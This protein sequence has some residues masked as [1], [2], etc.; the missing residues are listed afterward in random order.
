MAQRSVRPCAAPHLGSHRPR[1]H[2]SPRAVAQWVILHWMRLP[3][4]VA[5]ER[6]AK[7]DPELLA[8]IAEV[9]RTLIRAW[10]DR[11]PWERLTDTFEHYDTRQEMAQCL[12]QNSR[13]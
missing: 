5:R 3:S 12:R 1:A 13:R 7:L 9:D 11:D 4:V 8:G 6:L 2:E 10:L